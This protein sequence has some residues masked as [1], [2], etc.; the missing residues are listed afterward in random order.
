MQDT[1]LHING[2]V[3]QTTSVVVIGAP[4]SA[5]SLYFNGQ[6]LHFV[7]DTATGDW[8]AVVQY[9][10]PHL[11]VPQLS[12]LAWKYLDGLPEIAP[13]Y[14]DAAWTTADHVVTNNS[15][16][17]LATPTSLLSTDYGYNAGALIYRGH[18]VAQGN[19]TELL[20][21]TQGGTAYGSSAWLNSSYLGSWSGSNVLAQHNTSYALPILVPNEHYTFTI[22][23]DNN[24]YNHNWV[25][26]AEDMKS[27]RGILNYTLSGREQSAITWKLTG[28]LGGEKYVDKARGPL[29]EGGLYAERQGFTQPHPPSKD[30]KAG[31]PATGTDKAGVAFYQAT[32]KLEFPRRYDIPMSFNFGNTTIDGKVANYRAQ[33]WINGYQFGKYINNIGPQASFPVP[34]GMTFLKNVGCCN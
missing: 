18:F 7:V 10:D 25:V 31:N 17:S 6:K 11:D 1:S 27:P 5:R 15:A 19:E 21:W 29:N 12:S 22:V 28:N 3:N 33:L 23:V 20:V 30:W 13:T 34:Q 32:F 8:S 9:K 24:G 26:G 16:F 14:D 2:D 4:T